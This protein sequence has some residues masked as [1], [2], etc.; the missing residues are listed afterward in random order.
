[1]ITN[2]RSLKNI[3]RAEKYRTED[4]KTLKRRCSQLELE[5]CCDNIRS[6]FK[7]CEKVSE[8]DKKKTLEQCGAILWS[9]TNPEAEP[10]EIAKRLEEL[11]PTGHRQGQHGI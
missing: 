5:S 7:S 2:Q 8:A 4:Q 6:F 10:E 1:M 11:V 9:Y 3:A